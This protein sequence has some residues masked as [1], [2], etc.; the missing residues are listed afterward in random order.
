MKIVN[1]KAYHEYNMIQEFDAGIK[2][3]G[4]E[5][6]PLRAGEA[7][8]NDAYCLVSDNQVF[9]RNL[10]IAKNK[11]AHYTN[12]DEKRERL[13]LLNK[14]E[15][16]R[17]ESELKTNNGLTIIPVEIFEMNGRFKIKICLAK[18]KKLWDKKEHKKNKEVEREIRRNLNI[19]I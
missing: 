11:M 17:I 1:R 7:N 14:K 19:N 8:F 10:F 12:H 16:R 2:L 3:V 5:V 18:G 4:S 6:K 9:L 13:L 15:I